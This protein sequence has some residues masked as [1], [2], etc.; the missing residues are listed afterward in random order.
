MAKEKETDFRA[1]KPGDRDTALE[2]AL[3]P[4][5]DDKPVNDTP[6]EEQLN[7]VLPANAGGVSAAGIALVAVAI[8]IVLGVFFYGLNAPTTA[9]RVAAAPPPAQTTVPPAAGGNTGAPHANQSGGK[10]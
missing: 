2:E 9:D 5:V 8:A 10:G 3:R 4:R 6:V 1:S 7:A